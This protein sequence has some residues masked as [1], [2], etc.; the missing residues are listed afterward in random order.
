MNEED[1]DSKLPEPFPNHDHSFANEWTEDESQSHE[2]SENNTLVRGK[3]K[4]II[5]E[6]K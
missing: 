3:K 4:H 6:L 2:E 5:E 1:H